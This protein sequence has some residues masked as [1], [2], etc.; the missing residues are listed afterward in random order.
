MKRIISIILSLVI[1]TSAVLC[2]DLS[3]FA[4]EL[5]ISNR[6]EWLSQLTHIF[7]MTVEEDNYPDNYFS[8]LSSDSEYYHDILLAA[9]FGLINVEAGD[10]VNPN[11][12]ITRV[13]R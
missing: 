12:D 11:G 2:V 13:P 1:S 3:A 6:A 5:N 8:D 4:T 9:E 7:D 10:P